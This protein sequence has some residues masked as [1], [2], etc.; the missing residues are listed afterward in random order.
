MVWL[1]GR[2]IEEFDVKAFLLHNIYIYM[3]L[4]LFLE[5]A[6]LAQISLYDFPHVLAC[7]I[8]LD[9]TQRRLANHLHI[10]ES[11]NL[12]CLQV[13]KCPCLSVVTAWMVAAAPLKHAWRTNPASEWAFW[14]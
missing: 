12:V 2:F 8:R 1:V 7:V 10:S 13:T 14:C 5:A 3:I 4:H 11:A 9:T 6:T